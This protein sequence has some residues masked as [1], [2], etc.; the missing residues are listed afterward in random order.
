MISIRKAA[1]CWGCNYCQY[2]SVLDRMI[3]RHPEADCQGWDTAWECAFYKRRVDNGGG[4]C[5]ETSP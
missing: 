4:K 1:G 5:N 3:C 2:D